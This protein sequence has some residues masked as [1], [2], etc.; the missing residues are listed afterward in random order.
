MI[1]LLQ[2]IVTETE[3]SLSDKVKVT[4]IPEADWT[5]DTTILQK[6]STGTFVVKM[7]FPAS[8][9]TLPSTENEHKVELSINF[10]QAEK[11]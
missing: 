10:S 11:E 8:E 9:T 5:K 4:L 1:Y 2:E 3:K 7:E 6:D